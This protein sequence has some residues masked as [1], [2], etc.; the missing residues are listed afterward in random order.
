VVFPGAPSTDVMA[1]NDSGLIVGNYL[2]RHGRAHSFIV[3]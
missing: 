1:I 2:D 3:R